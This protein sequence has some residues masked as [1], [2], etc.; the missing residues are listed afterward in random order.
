MSSAVP[1][2]AFAEVVIRPRQ[3]VGHYWRELWRYRELF[4][5][6]AWRDVK[7]RYK[8][9][10]IGV[11]WAVLRPLLVMVVFTIVFGRLGKMPSPGG[12]PYPLL[13]MAGMLPWQFFA[14]VMGE[15]SNSLLLN[16]NLVTK[17]YFPRII[18]P[19][20]V[21][22]VSLVDLMVSGMLMVGLLG[23]YRQAPSIQ[24][25][26]L[27]LFLLLGLAASLGASFWLSALTV[28]YRDFRYVIPFVVQFGLYATPVG[29]STA[30][31]PERWRPVFALNPMVGVV[32]GFRWSV[33]GT[34]VLD[35][36]VL[37]ASTATTLL[38]LMTGFRYFRSTERQ[39]ADTI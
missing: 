29:F 21:V 17:M 28:K 23:W 19:A 16:A 18:V 26:A 39:F 31:I 12:L 22:V 24:A 5:F 32:E 3:P 34:G 33:L 2:A 15:G 37:S 36:W 7:I 27:P 13:V 38:L 10:T 20:S 9:T 35:G 14:T 11:A 4:L 8:Q 30:S 1:P 25:L 6:L